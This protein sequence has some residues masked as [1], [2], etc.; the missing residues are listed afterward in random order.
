MNLD[1]WY[2]GPVYPGG[3]TETST[4]LDDRLERLSHDYSPRVM[5]VLLET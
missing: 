4:C 5:V 2:D 1:D 3:R